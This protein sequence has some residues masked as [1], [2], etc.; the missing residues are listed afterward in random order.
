MRS[1]IVLVVCASVL[2]GG[3]FLAPQTYEYAGERGPLNWGR[4]APAWAACSTG[5]RQS[6]ID[7]SPSVATAGESL[8]IAYGPT[9]GHIFNNGHTIEVETEGKNGLT[10]RGQRFELA[11]FHFHAPSE[12]RAG[13][14][15]YE[16]EL[17]LVHRSSEGQLAVVGVFLT[18]GP[19][20]KALDPVFDALPA[21]GNM[22]KTA[23][24]AP[25]N[26]ADFLPA[27]RSHF[28]YEG[29][30]T[31]PPC[32]EGVTWFVLQDPVTVSDDH[33]ARFAKLIP[34]NARP[35]QKR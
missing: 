11:Q 2:A 31:T 3:G 35:I 19:S 18:R 33:L 15:S 12:H 26:P 22:S 30:L 24:L 9:R 5:G 6:P 23:L 13:G 29:S 1:S 17:H 4:L 20:S 34:F 14:R 8:A 21:P 10:V 32:A 16:M 7:L 28:T 25:F 27:R